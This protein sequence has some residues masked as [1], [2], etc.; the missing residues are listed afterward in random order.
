MYFNMYTV[1]IDKVQKS[2]KFI[3]YARTKRGS[4]TNK[5]ATAIALELEAIEVTTSTDSSSNKYHAH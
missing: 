5:L 3:V 4:A 1:L 2:H